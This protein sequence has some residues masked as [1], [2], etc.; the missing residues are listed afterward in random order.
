MI[1]KKNTSNYLYFIER[2]IKIGR[3]TLHK[4]KYSIYI[5]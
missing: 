1:I 2:L 5:F 3:I 4:T